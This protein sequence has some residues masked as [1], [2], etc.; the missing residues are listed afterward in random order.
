[1]NENLMLLILSTSIFIGY[2]SW[3]L[4]RE[5]MI[6]S[7]SESYYRL[8]YSLKVFFTLF[9]WGMAVP[10]MI[11]SATPLM[12]AA[13]FF[14]CMVGTTQTFKIKLVGII[15]TFAAMTGIGLGV[16][17]LFFEFRTPLTAIAIIMSAAV[18]YGF[19]VKNK[20]FWT[21]IISFTMILL[22]LF[23]TQV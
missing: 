11:V 13:C 9:I 10:I 6:P 18:L 17:S 8:P 12:I 21:E 4:S 22:S 2:V 19:N 23:L 7:I 3:I 20:V 16:L 1:M 15:H 14:I 5:G